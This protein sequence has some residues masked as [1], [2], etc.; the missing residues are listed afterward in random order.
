MSRPRKLSYL[1]FG[2][3]AILPTRFRARGKMTAFQKGLEKL[4]SE[5]DFTPY[6]ADV[7]LLSGRKQGKRSDS[8]SHSDE[9][10]EENESDVK[11]IKG[12]KPHEDYASLFGDE[13]DEDSDSS[14]NFIVE[15]DGAIPQSLPAEFSMESHQDLSH[16]FKRVFQFFVHIAVRPPADRHEFMLDQMRG[17]RFYHSSV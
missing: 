8:I 3:V 13:P 16:Q 11:P 4:K 14:S 5:D 9:S 12:A 1:S 15:D 17:L 10:Q 6:D 2:N 7:I